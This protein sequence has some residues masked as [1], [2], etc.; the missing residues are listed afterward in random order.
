MRQVSI[1]CKK[2]STVVTTAQLVDAL[3]SNG[4]VQRLIVELAEVNINATDQFVASKSVTISRLQG[5]KNQS[6]THPDMEGRTFRSF[7]GSSF[8]DYTIFLIQ[9]SGSSRGAFQE[10]KENNNVYMLMEG[11][12]EEEQGGDHLTD[13]IITEPMPL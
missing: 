3:R 9:S 12:L 6:D 11:E 13:A 8:D 1:F 2:R 4:G 7:E 10:Q 5:S